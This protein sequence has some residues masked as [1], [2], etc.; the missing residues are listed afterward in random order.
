MKE[1]TFLEK[2]SVARKSTNFLGN[3]ILIKR[4]REGSSGVEK[5]RSGSWS[6]VHL[7]GSDADRNQ[8]QQSHAWQVI[9]TMLKHGNKGSANYIFT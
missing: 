4:Q 5:Q 9:S 8:P 3:R 2:A 7:E 6:T 1:N